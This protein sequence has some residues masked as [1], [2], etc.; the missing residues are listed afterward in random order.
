MEIWTIK[1]VYMLVDR[2]GE[3]RKFEARDTKK[4]GGA[5]SDSLPPSG[6]TN[7]LPPL[8]LDCLSLDSGA[9]SVAYKA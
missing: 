7:T 8:K 4:L 1:K 6:S 9:P 3:K 2:A 5:S